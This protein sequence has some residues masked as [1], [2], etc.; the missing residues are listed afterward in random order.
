MS[1]TFLLETSQPYKLFCFD[2][3]KIMLLTTSRLELL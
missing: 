3:M 2:N 1:S